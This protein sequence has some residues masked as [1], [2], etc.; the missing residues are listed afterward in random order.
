M[1]LILF[2]SIVWIVSSISLAVIVRSGSAKKKSLVAAS[3][4]FAAVVYSTYRIGEFDG[5]GRYYAALRSELSPFLRKISVASEET[6][7]EAIRDFFL[8][9]DEIKTD[10]SEYLSS[11]K[12]A[13]DLLKKE[14]NQSL[15]P[16]APSGRG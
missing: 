8:G 2:L 15:Q 14:P 12:H 6:K 9:A 11:L 7:K 10:P 5:E 16:T 3:V 1:P 4:A 13:H